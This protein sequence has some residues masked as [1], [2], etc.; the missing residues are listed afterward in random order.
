MIDGIVE[1][2]TLGGLG[3]GGL[4]SFWRST[5]GQIQK[6]CDA[7]EAEVAT[8]RARVAFLEGVADPFPTALVDPSGV[9]E[10]VNNGFVSWCLAHRVLD[11]PSTAVVGAD[12]AEL[13]PD[14]SVAELRD[15]MRAA[16]L[17]TWATAPRVQLVPGRAPF[18]VFCKV[19][20]YSGALRFLFVCNPVAASAPPVLVLEAG[21]T[22]E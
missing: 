22:V 5:V 12:L 11:D 20:L 16:S 15:V 4:W 3:V 9:V 6:R 10:H 13:F 2:L 18:A 1:L 19:E 7:N 17:S 8:L 14:A 21:D